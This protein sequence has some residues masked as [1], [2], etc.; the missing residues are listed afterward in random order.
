MWLCI[1]ICDG[2]GGG[3][4]DDAAACVFSKQREYHVES[5]SVATDSVF[6]QGD[7]CDRIRYSI[8]PLDCCQWMNML[9]TDCCA[10]PCLLKC[11]SQVS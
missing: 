8:V 6:E 1:V 11:V 10:N 5:V 7:G 4:V 3:S 9:S 2:G